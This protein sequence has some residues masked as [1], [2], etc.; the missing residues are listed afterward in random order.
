MNPS[1]AC[2]ALTKAFEGYKD[3]AYPD[4]GT[5]GAPWTIAYGHTSGVTK[6]M[7][8]T[9]DQGEAWLV[10][11]LSRAADI[12]NQWVKVELNQNQFD[13]CCDFV[14]NVGPG[15]VGKRDGFVWLRNGNH[16]TML[17]LLNA[18]EFVS[19]D[20]EGKLGGAAAEFPK[21]D[22]P[23]L[24]GIIR[25]RAAEQALFLR[26]DNLEVKPTT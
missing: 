1:P 15:M 20:A 25:R 8:C 9:Q 3:T 5:G 13:A 23:P 17:R 21:W 2:F 6:G 11:D 19:Y 10:S 26:D 16:S 4:P 14:Y 24:P 22:L 7:T 12:V 18:G